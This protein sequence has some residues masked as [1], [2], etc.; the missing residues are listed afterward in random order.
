M[1]IVTLTV[2]DLDLDAGTYKVDFLAEGSEIDDGQATAAY[3]TGFYLNT[4]VNTPDFLAGAGRFG[5]DLIDAL[6][7]DMPDRPFSQSPAKMALTLVDK[8]LDTGRYNV[9]LQNEG[10]DPAG[11]SL[12]TTAQVVGTYMRYLLSDMDFRD[13]VWAFADEYVAKNGSASIG[14]LDQRPAN[15][16]MAA[17][18]A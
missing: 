15:D 17:A 1:A 2:S 14:N 16:S 12:P 10:G 6:T 8:N 13:K 9:T 7:R 4:L 18:A 5:R 3:F 11:E